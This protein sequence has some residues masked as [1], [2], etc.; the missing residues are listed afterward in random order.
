MIKILITTLLL[1]LPFTGCQKQPEKSDTTIPSGKDSADI[2]KFEI[3]NQKIGHFLEQLDDPETPLELRQQLICKDYPAVYYNEYVP[4]LIE[5]S[6]EYT[7]EELR[8]DL[9]KVLKFY[10]E[11]DDVQC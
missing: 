9:N 2:I 6:P 8:S 1:S 5:L 4:A 7:S 3:A 10:K 11:K